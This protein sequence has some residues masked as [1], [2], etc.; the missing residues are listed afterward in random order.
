MANLV[1]LLA[2]SD[3][4]GKSNHAE[5][6][7]VVTKLESYAPAKERP[8]EGMPIPGQMVP[9]RSD[10]VAYFDFLLQF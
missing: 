6:E 1:D 7:E 10:Q 3:S 5:I 9:A 4:K 2:G 8:P